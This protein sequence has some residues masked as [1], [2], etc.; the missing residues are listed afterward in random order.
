MSLPGTKVH[1]CRS[2]TWVTPSTAARAERNSSTSMCLGEDS[3][4]IRRAALASAIALGSTHS[5]TRTA[6]T[7]SAYGQRVVT[8]TTPAISTPTLL[9]ASAITSM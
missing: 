8:I 3:E 2:C 1:T 6:T 9:T 5:A 7:V 4:R